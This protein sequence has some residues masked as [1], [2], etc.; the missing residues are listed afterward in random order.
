MRRKRRAKN[1]ISPP[2]N[3]TINYKGSRENGKKAEKKPRLKQRGIFLP[4]TKYTK[5]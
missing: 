5:Y 4:L 1:C 2:S 3:V